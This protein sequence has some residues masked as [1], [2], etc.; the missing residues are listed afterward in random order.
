MRTP[1]AL[2][3]PRREGLDHWSSGDGAASAGRGGA[4]P[5]RVPPHRAPGGLFDNPRIAGS[6]RASKHGA[7]VGT[8]RA[9]KNDLER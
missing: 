5:G 1:G 3:V 4:N 2:W 6:V 8:K 9:H 7:N